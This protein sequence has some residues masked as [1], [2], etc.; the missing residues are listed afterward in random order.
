MSSSLAA[1]IPPPVAGFI[2]TIY[3]PIACRGL[4]ASPPTGVRFR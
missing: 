2:R 3:D 1:P 4:I